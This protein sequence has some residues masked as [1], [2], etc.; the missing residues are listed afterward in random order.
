[1]EDISE[2]NFTL[3]GLEKFEYNQNSDQSRTSQT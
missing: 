3:F 1:M 2:E